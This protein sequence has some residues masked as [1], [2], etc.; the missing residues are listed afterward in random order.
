MKSSGQSSQ[1]PLTG[2]KVVEFEGI[3][4]GPLAGFHLV[5]LGASV[6]LV[7]RPG[8]G[9][10][11]AEMTPPT[12]SLINR[13]KHRVT[14]N[15]KTPR[16]KA[17]AIDLIAQSDALIEGNRPGVMERLGLGPQDCAKMNPR[18]VYGRMTGWGQDGPLA[19]AAGHDMNYVALTGL[20][21]LTETPGHPPILPPT[22]LG[23][24]A[25]AL[26]L[27][28]GIVAGLLSA[29]S[30]EGKGCVV[31]GAIVDVLALLAPLVQLLRKGGALEGTAA[32]VFHDSPFYDRYRCAD[33]RYVTVGA[34][35]PQFYALLL[36]KMG[37]FDVDPSQQ[38]NRASW[39]ALKVRMTEA[40]ASRSSRHWIRELEGSDACFAPV[41]TLEEAAKHPH[42][43]SRGLYRLTDEGDIETARGLRF[44]PLVDQ[45]HLK[46]PQ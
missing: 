25:G 34:I 5:Q 30:G 42:N 32:S 18:L 4:P 12:D 16:D 38:M 26:G 8:R 31:D 46:S 19:N 28:M 43:V 23:D 39:P 29:R 22:V 1:L 27:T 45:D 3:G 17:A 36:E 10:L 20:M 14:L 37:L 7:A 11:P 44:L 2:V 33:G 40:F 6:T 21:S 15:L 24:A 35:E 41:L 9:A 13:G